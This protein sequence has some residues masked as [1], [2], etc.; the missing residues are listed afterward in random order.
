MAHRSY[1]S[2]LYNTLVSDKLPSAKHN[3][4]LSIAIP[5]FNVEQYLEECVDSLNLAPQHKLE[6]LIINDG[7]TDDTLRVA[8][9]VSSKNQNVTLISKDN[10]GHGSAINLALQKAKG[11]YFKLLDGDDWLEP[12][13]LTEFLSFL[14]KTNADIV[15]TDY[16]E[17]YMSSGERRSV[18][19]YEKLTPR[20]LYSLKS[21]D[22]NNY[23]PFQENGPLLPSTTFKTSIFKDRPFHI[24]EHCYYVDMEYN[25][26]VYERAQSVIYLPV[27]LYI[28]R[29]DRTGQSMHRSSLVNK[30]K[31]HEQVCIRLVE[32]LDG[33]DHPKEQYD[34]L[35]QRIVAPMC[36]SHYQIVAELLKSRRAFLDFDKKLKSHPIIYKSPLVSGKIIAIHRFSRGA[37]LPINAILRGAGKVL[38]R[39]D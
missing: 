39:I 14:A 28:Y 7:S 24:D 13:V 16:I 38:N 20:K 31:D 3:P 33:K 17:Y 19:N 1:Y 27:G 26:F 23:P 10:G 2:I 6:I 18:K 5:A 15:L 22:K 21:S 11:K 25:F 29:L 4:L 8:E 30:Y 36:R 35:F 32:E 12:A 9:R 34:Y 37:T